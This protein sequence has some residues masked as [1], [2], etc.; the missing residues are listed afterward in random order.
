MKW[1]FLRNIFWK[2][3]S[4]RKVDT[5]SLTAV[6]WVESMIR[7]MSKLC[8]AGVVLCHICPVKM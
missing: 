6:L 7:Q 5:A 2:L 8:R 4:L 1:F 3:K